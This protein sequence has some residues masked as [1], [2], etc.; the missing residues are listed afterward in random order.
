MPFNK[1]FNALTTEQQDQVRAKFD[2]LGENDTP[3]YPASGLQAVYKP[4]IN[5]NKNYGY[6]RPLKLTV[7][8]D[9]Q[10]DVSNVDIHSDVNSRL[11][12]Y[13]ERSLRRT[14]FE[15]AMCNGIACEM[16][17]PVDITFN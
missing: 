3:P 1:R 7:T 14:K 2:A 16:N 10:G 9:K 12:A 6:N 17:F 15:P 4:L 13:V 8:V 11:T 5:A